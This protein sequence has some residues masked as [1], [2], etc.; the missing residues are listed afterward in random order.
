MSEKYIRNHFDDIKRYANTIES[1]LDDGYCT[2]ENV[3]RDNACV[4]EQCK[5]YGFGYILIDDE[6][7]VDINL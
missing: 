6:Y 2:M 4:L 7:D 3:L 1:R 5:A